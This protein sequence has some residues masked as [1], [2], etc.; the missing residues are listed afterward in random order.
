MKNNVIAWLD[1]NKDVGILL[2]RLFVGIR[3]IY[4]VVDNI[5]DWERM[6]EFRNFLEQQGFPLPLAS[7]VISVYAQFIAG[8]M[9]IL[10]FKIRLAAVLMIINF[11]V[12]LVMVHLHDSF[13]G[14]TPALSMLCSSILFLFDGAG[15]FALKSRRVNKGV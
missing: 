8:L 9:F 5:V 15:K 11:L 3:L 10:G 7:A 13:E 4:G 14:M 1:K 12:A 2:L 6:L